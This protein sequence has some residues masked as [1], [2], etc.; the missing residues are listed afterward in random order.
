MQVPEEFS[1]PRQEL[2]SLASKPAS[3][4]RERPSTARR[5]QNDAGKIDRESCDALVKIWQQIAGNHWR[6]RL[7]DS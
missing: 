7:R 4:T 1:K 5:S 2:L 6:C 3:A